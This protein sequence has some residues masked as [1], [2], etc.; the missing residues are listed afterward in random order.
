MSG[1][2]GKKGTARRNLLKALVAGSGAF[3]MGKK[4]PESWVKPLVKSVALPAHA[5]TS[6]ASGPF[7]GYYTKLLVG[8]LD[9]NEKKNNDVADSI[10]DMFVPAAEAEIPYG[11]NNVT[12][13]QI[14]ISGDKADV[15]VSSGFAAYQ[16]TTDVNT[17]SGDLN[18][19]LSVGSSA[20]SLTSMKVT[21]SPPQVTGTSNCPSLTGFVAPLINGTFKC[22]PANVAS[23]IQLSSPFEDIG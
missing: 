10:L 22:I 12:R 13:L 1:G 23:R 16:D 8:M 9:P 21:K 19:I 18:N 17:A 14:S 7:D 3:A 6:P 11:C 2:Q 15:C 4:V 5:Q 20:I